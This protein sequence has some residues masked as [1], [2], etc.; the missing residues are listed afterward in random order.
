MVV[1]YLDSN[2]SKRNKNR[3]NKENNKISGFNTNK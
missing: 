3:R 1:I 2:K